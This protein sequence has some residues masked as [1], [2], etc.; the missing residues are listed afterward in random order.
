MYKQLFNLILLNI[1]FFYIISKSPEEDYEKAA[2]DYKNS[3]IKEFKQKVVDYLSKKDLYKNDKKLINKEEFKEIFR[4]LMSDGNENNVSEDFGDTFNS[5]TELFVND[6]FP[7][8]VNTMKGS[9]I[10]KYFE[11]ENIMDKFNKYMA[12]AYQQN[13]PNKQSDL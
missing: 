5:L 4:Y 9:D 6:A 3:Y 7:N 2:E 1:F 11:Y 8:G 12:K 13:D 10:D